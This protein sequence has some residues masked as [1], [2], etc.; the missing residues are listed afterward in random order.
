[1]TLT[2]E[3]DV[4]IDLCQSNMQIRQASH[5]G[6]VMPGKINVRCEKAGKFRGSD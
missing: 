6:I 4:I 2:S 3:Q 5:E 1:M